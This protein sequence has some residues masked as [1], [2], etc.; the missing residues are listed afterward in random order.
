MVVPGKDGSRQL[1][2][3]RLGVTAPALMDSA[4]ADEAVDSGT[5]AEILTSDPPL[6][7]LGAPG[8]PRP[9][10]QDAVLVQLGLQVPLCQGAHSL[11]PVPSLGEVENFTIADTHPVVRRASGVGYQ[12]LARLGPL[13]ETGHILIS[14][15]PDVNPLPRQQPWSGSPAPAAWG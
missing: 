13:M 14:N 11:W 1:L 4:G 5:F 6:P 8:Q 12:P 7:V 3:V 15:A 2:G 10:R 9:W